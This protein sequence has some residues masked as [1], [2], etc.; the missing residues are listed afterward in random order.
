MCNG[1]QWGK[2]DKNNTMQNIS[3]IFDYMLITTPSGVQMVVGKVASI[4]FGFVIQRK[5]NN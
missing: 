3:H 1:R 2:M 5:S 4:S